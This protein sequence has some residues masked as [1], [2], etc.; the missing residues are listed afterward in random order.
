MSD[1]DLY[2]TDYY[3]WTRQ[4]AEAL[5]KLARER[6]NVPLDLEHLI[7]EVEDLGRSARNTCLSQTERVIRHLLK[8]EYSPAQAPRRQW[9]LSILDARRELHRHLTPAIRP[10]LV[11]ELPDL[12]RAARR[13]AALELA[14]LDG[15]EVADKLPEEP[16]YT[17]EELLDE[18]WLPVAP[19]PGTAR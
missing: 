11:A 19:E 17:L 16:S 8:L 4:Q 1:A 7:E 2:E 18:D 15:P 6:S 14:D 9:Q 3:A 13:A 10:I 12:A 5:R